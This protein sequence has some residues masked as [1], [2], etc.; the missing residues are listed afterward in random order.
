[1]PKVYQAYYNDQGTKWKISGGSQAKIISDARQAARDYGV[2]VHVDILDIEKPSMKY[3][4]ECMNGRKPNKR[5]RV[6][7]YVP[8][9]RPVNSGGKKRWKIR[10]K[11][12]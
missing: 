5:T 11:R 3:I 7:S 6:C 2:E 10:K 1:M 12:G 8:M 4:I 9:G